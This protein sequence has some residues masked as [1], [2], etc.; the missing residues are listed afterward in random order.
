M[1]EENKEKLC[2]S[3]AKR[4]IDYQES[5][6]PEYYHFY[7]GMIHAMKLMGIFIEVTF[8]FD[9]EIDGFICDNRIY[10]LADYKEK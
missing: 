4:I 1:T 6:D 10:K 5:Y 8:N 9:C 2:K 3:L 7:K